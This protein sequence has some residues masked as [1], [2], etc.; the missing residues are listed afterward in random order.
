MKKYDYRKAIIK[1]IKQYIK[2]NPQDWPD[3]REIDDIEEYWYDIL[4]YTDGIVGNYGNWYDTEEKC[5][6]YLCHNINLVYEAAR[7]FCIDDD[8]NILIEH[9][10]NKSLA[11]YFDCMVRCYLLM[12]C[13]HK[14]LEEL[15][16]S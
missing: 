3:P 16:E 8:I 13:V 11:R 15:N 2:N 5:A 9:Y 1:D 14:A 4:W 10:E 12:E 7:E 6:E